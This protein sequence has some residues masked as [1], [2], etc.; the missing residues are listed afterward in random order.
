MHF[1][2]IPTREYLK[3]LSRFSAFQTANLIS[4]LI[5]CCTLAVYIILAVLHIAPS[6]TVFQILAGVLSYMTLDFLLCL[7]FYHDFSRQNSVAT[8]I[9]DDQT[10]QVSCCF[11]QTHLSVTS[12]GGIDINHTV[13]YRD[14]KKM[15]AWRRHIFLMVGLEK[16]TLY[17]LIPASAFPSVQE[18][19]K[20]KQY[21]KT[22]IKQYQRP[23]MRQTVLGRFI[24]GLASGYWSFLTVT[25]KSVL[26]CIAALAALCLILFIISILTASPPG[27]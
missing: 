21:I 6:L 17:L 18:H 9:Q 27:Y 8:Y 26:F 14:I 12:D 20:A 3:T 10:P 16:S 25:L 15:I 22:S 23:E 1:N 24:K 11:F 13:N 2:F 5:L 7:K 4:Q 19:K